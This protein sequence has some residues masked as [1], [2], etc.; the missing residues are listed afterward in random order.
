MFG[1]IAKVGLTFIIYWWII[2]SEPEDMENLIEKFH[3]NIKEDN[4]TDG[5]KNDEN[6]SSLYF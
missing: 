3:K 4:N 1:C 5:E 2:Q 6:R